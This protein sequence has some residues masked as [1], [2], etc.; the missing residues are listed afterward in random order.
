MSVKHIE[1]VIVHSGSKGGSTGCGTNTNEHPSHWENTGS[2]IN[3]DKN[4]C[5]N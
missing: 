5:K 4:G 3:C 1:T 2:S